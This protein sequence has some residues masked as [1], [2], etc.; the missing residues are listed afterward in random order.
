MESCRTA[1]GRSYKGQSYHAARWAAPVSRALIPVAFIVEG[2]P[3][4]VPDVHGM[5][6]EVR[7]AVQRD[8]SA[9]WKATDGASP[10]WV[11]NRDGRLEWEPQPSSR[12]AAFIRRTRFATP[13]EAAEALVAALVNE[14]AMPAAPPPPPQEART[15]G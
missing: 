3:P 14:G 5:E 13:E 7:R 9:L 15:D 2:V 12:T 1:G 11:A 4:H 10:A 8:G 6:W